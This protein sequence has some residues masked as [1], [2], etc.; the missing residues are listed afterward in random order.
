MDALIVGGEK[1]ILS[2]FFNKL[3][4][5]GIEP[6]W[7]WEWDE[8]QARWN[9]PD[10]AEGVIILK[11]M[12]N[13]R[14]S[15]KARD[16]AKS[17][18][19]PVCC[20]DSKF[21]RAFPLLEQRGWTTQSLEDAA[22]EEQIS[23]EEEEEK[24]TMSESDGTLLGFVLEAITML[25]EEDPEILMDKVALNKKA[26]DFIEVPLEESALADLVDQVLSQ[27]EWLY[28]NN[29]LGVEGAF[30][31]YTSSTTTY[32]KELDLD[33]EEMTLGISAF[34]KA[35]TE[36]QI[37]GYKHNGRW[38]TSYQAILDFIK[39]YVGTRLTDPEALTDLVFTPVGVTD[40]QLKHTEP[41]EPSEVLEEEDDEIIVSK[42]QL[43]DMIDDAV[44]EALKPLNNKM[45]IL[46]GSLGAL[47]EG[48]GKQGEKNDKT[49]GQITETQ[50]NL[51]TFEERLDESLNEL[52]ELW[53]RRFREYREE[54]G[55]LTI[56]RALDTDSELETKPQATEKVQEVVEHTLEC[57]P[58]MESFQYLLAMGAK[59]TV[60]P[61]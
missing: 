61:R 26:P 47:A 30:D 32:T 21:S 49:R 48:L 42:Q 44:S 23:E 4:T 37:R 35:F 41:T 15:N 28:K 5:V 13:H 3:R 43:K 46:D 39:H 24:E 58:G 27:N 51:N 60:E 7:H 16:E 11:N 54:V 19:V 12:T 9:F 20:V 10:D 57:P 38:L 53:E 56:D 50:K 22:R 40:L 1:T 31:Y 17:R 18:G 45:T 52:K 6:R 2:T 29:L 33:A 14:P 36:R 59:I 8:G 34:R 25:A 55:K